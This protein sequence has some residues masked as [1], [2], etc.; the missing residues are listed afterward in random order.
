MKIERAMQLFFKTLAEDN[1]IQTEIMNAEDEIYLENALQEIAVRY[2]IEN[3][4]E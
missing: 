3:T 2:V 4:E 1:N